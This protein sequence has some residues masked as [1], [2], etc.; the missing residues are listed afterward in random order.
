M[1]VVGKLGNW[2]GVDKSNMDMV[3]L[4]LECGVMAVKRKEKWDDGWKDMYY[5]GSVL[6]KESS[7]ASLHAYGNGP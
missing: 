4:S 5:K 2:N 1:E 3:T 6:K 7:I